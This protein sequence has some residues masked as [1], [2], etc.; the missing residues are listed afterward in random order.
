MSGYV[1]VQEGPYLGRC[2]LCT[3]HKHSDVCNDGN[4]KCQVR[5]LFSAILIIYFNFR[6]RKFQILSRFQERI[7]VLNCV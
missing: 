3:C 6:Q 5:S 4:G 7:K 1:R 2:E